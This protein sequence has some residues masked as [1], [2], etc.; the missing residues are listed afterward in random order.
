MTSVV[1]LTLLSPPAHRVPWNRERDF[2]AEKV[3]V[4]SSIAR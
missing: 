4:V 3:A 2:G 1:K